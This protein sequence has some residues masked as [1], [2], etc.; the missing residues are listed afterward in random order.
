MLVNNL[1]IY[2]A[3]FA[4]FATLATLTTLVNFLNSL[5]L[6]TSLTF[7]T[8]GFLVFSN[9]A[10]A[11][12]LNLNGFSVEDLQCNMSKMIGGN[13]INNSNSPF[14]GNLKVQIISDENKVVWSGKERVEVK[15]HNALKFSINTHSV[16]C[17]AP[18]SIKVSLGN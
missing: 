8:F 4:T 13:L 11:V 9:S 2:L 12:S 18:S 6:G 5:T 10:F 17:T 15:A 1:S 16:S 3:T 14:K 7:V